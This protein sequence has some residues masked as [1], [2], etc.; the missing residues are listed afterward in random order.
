MP[1]PAAYDAVAFAG[2][3]EHVRQDDDRWTGQRYQIQWPEFAKG[4]LM[5]A[6]LAVPGATGHGVP[7]LV[8]QAAGL[9]FLVDHLMF[10]INNFYCG[11][12]FSPRLNHSVCHIPGREVVMLDEYHTL[13]SASC[14]YLVPRFQMCIL[15]DC[16]A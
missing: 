10:M 16:I 3:Q 14:V 6:V 4:D 12:I 13:G 1:H 8:L 7:A 11:H 15:A 2:E 9:V 5:P